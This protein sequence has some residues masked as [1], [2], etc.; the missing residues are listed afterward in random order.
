[1]RHLMTYTINQSNECHIIEHFESCESVFYESLKNRVNI[2]EHSKKLYE[3]AIRYEAWDN[4][5]GGGNALV[6]LLAT[7][8]NSQWVYITNISIAESY[9][10]NGIGTKLMNML[11][12]D[13]PNKIFELEVDL[14]NENAIRFYKKFGFETTSFKMKRK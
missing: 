14:Y 9:K 5:V 11:L 10:R 8:V 13:N 2:I 3:K 1:M 12:T 6:G 4:V 7:Y